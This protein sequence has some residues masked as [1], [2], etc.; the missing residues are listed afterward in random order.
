[1]R[2]EEAKEAEEAVLRA[3]KIEEAEAASKA[4]RDY[5]YKADEDKAIYWEL[6]KAKQLDSLKDDA[7]S[8]ARIAKIAS[9]AYYVIKRSEYKMDYELMGFGL[10]TPDQVRI[11]NHRAFMWE[12]Q[13][14]YEKHA[15]DVSYFTYS[16]PEQCPRD[17]ANIIAQ[18]KNM[19]AHICDALDEFKD[20]EGTA[21]R[22]PN[23]YDGT[24]VTALEKI[25]QH[26]MLM[27]NYIS[28]CIELDA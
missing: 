21:L 7:I 3:K 12:L 2:T 11:S 20:E 8:H 1:M 25:K 16:I 22:C 18:E 6:K 14:V 19:L 24:L 15:H 10:E 13:N 17:L 4:A 5:K 27:Y 9:H 26:H 28:R 23:V